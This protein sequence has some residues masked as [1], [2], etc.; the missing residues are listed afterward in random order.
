MRSWLL[1]PA[2]CAMCACSGDDSHRHVTQPTSGITPNPK[3]D[4]GIAG[5]P[6][7]LSE[8]MAVSYWT[9]PDEQA[10]ITAFTAKDFTAAKAAL[11]TARAAVKDP[12]DP[13]A[14]RLELLLLLVSALL[15]S[16]ASPLRNELWW[17]ACAILMLLA[18][19][20]PH[21]LFRA[22]LRSTP[23][24]RWAAAAVVASQ[25]LVQCPTVAQDVLPDGS[26]QQLSLAD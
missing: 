10:G 9:T 8:S 22:T 13:Q 14:P 4:G 3:S 7:T 19:L 6:G 15:L 11:T 17:P 16:V 26:C 1:V 12:N 20:A 2:L 25:P 5:A 21:A 18:T 23:P 24:V